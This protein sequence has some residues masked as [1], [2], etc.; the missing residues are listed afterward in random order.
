MGQN[1]TVSAGSGWEKCPAAAWGLGGK[2]L[3][4]RH[5]KG[6][7]MEGSQ[8]PARGVQCGKLPPE[9]RVAT[10]S[11]LLFKSEIFALQLPLRIVWGAFK[12]Y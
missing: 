9:G 12:K 11:G 5:R 8:L 6:E 2:T 4:L 1:I 3:A 7:G 10:V